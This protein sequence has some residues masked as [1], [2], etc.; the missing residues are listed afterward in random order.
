MPCEF[1]GLGHGA[2]GMSSVRTRRTAVDGRM[3]VDDGLGQR[4]Q[5]TREID[6]ANRAMGVGLLYQR[7]SLPRPPTG[8][9]S[10]FRML[11]ST[12]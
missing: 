10:C 3:H 2:S 7:R 9:R 1:A 4:K 5:V 12:R 11:K 8:P 6:T